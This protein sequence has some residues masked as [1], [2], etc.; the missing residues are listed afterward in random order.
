M[1][2]ELNGNLAL[3]AN[4]MESNVKLSPVDGNCLL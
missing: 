1:E 2:H 4:G 3:S